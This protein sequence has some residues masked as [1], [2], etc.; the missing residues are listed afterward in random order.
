MPSIQE[1][2]GY[3]ENEDN[4][5]WVVQCPLNVP[6]ELV[7]LTNIIDMT[8]NYTNGATYHVVHFDDLDSIR[9][10]TSGFIA[11]HMFA[12]Y[13][14]HMKEDLSYLNALNSIAENKSIIELSD[15]YIG[16]AFS[17]LAWRQ[18]A[19]YRDRCTEGDWL[20][21]FNDMFQRKSNSSTLAINKDYVQLR[22]CA[23]LL[24]LYI[25]KQTESLTLKTMNPNRKDKRVA[26]SNFPSDLQ[27]FVERLAREYPKPRDTLKGG[28]S[29]KKRELPSTSK[30]FHK[31]K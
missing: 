19:V 13:L 1:L 25:H 14:T 17:N 3:N 29:K 31:K 20:R 30:S 7:I 23:K 15:W 10:N 5:R 26:L 28:K 9:A 27:D 24:L 8:Y 16:T 6:E 4:N 11:A 21:S 22:M 12:E 2:F 18:A